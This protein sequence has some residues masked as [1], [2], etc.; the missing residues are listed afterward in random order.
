MACRSRTRASRGRSPRMPSSRRSGSAAR[1]A[2]GGFREVFEAVAGG[3]AGRG[4]CRS[5][6]SSTVR[7]A[8]STTCCSSTTSRSPAR[9]SCRSTCAWRR[10]RA[11]PSTTSSG[12]TRTS[13][14]WARR[15]GS[16]APALDSPHDLQHR[17]R[18]KVRRRSGRSRGAAAV[19]SRRAAERGS[20]SR[21]SPSHPGR[22]RQS[23]AVPRRGA[24]GND[25]RRRGRAT[26]TAIPD[27]PRLRRPKRARNAP[28]ALR[29]FADRSINL[30]KLESGRAARRPGSTSSGP[31]S[32]PIGPTPT[33]PRRSTNWPGRHDGPGVRLVSRASEAAP[34]AEAQRP[35][36]GRE[37]LHQTVTNLP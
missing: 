15:S 25:A 33:V 6:T 8:R 32:T 9:S 13:R 4:S 11:A 24:A 3:E 30:S 35:W 36:K 19:L 26:A 14:R 16:C 12:C 7:S 10:C 23:D 34:T 5:R 21:F 2:V 1:L 20:G 18:R 22:A 17:R 31:T 29:V 27:D 37:N 28:A